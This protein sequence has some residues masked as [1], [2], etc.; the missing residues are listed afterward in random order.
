MG[1]S[2][3]QGKRQIIVIVE[4]GLGY[5]LRGQIT[6]LV[7]SF[8]VAQITRPMVLMGTSV[9]LIYQFAYD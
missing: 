4:T 2:R 7:A 3:W 1:V 8:M 6:I 5:G 9:G